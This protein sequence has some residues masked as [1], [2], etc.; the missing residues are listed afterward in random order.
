MRRGKLSIFLSGCAA[1]LFTFAH[2]TAMAAPIFFGPTPYLSAADIP[3]G[4]YLGG[5]PLGLEDFEDGSLDFGLTTSSGVI[6]HPGP[7]PGVDSV[8]ADDGTIDGSGSLGHNLETVTGVLI[9]F[10]SAVTAAA[11]VWTDGARDGTVT[12]E[13]FG[14]GLVS[15]VGG[16]SLACPDAQASYLIF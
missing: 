16:R 12:F 9:T 15:R 6:A 8:D 4:F 7:I 13:A 5:S 10:P 1:V 14:P 2:A 11:M 3:A